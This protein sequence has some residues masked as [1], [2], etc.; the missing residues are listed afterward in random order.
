MATFRSSR[1]RYEKWLREQL[2]SDL[3]LADLTKKSRVMRESSFKFLRAT[4]WRWSE[5]IAE[6]CPEVVAAPLV[7]AVG[8]IHLENFGTW[9]DAEGRL[10]FGVNDF[11]EAAEM[12]FTLDLVRLAAS[13][14]LGSDGRKRT[15]ADVSAAI[16]AGYRQGLDAP[17]PI[18]LDREWH[19]LRNAVV[20][21]EERRSKFW[22]EL[23]AVVFEPAPPRF[24]RALQRV[25]PEGSSRLQTARRTAGTGSLGRPRWLG[26]TAWRGAPAIREAKALLT[27]GWCLAQGKPNAAL[28][29]DEIAGGRF[30]SPDPWYRVQDAIVVRRLSPNNRKF[31]AGKRSAFLHE[32]SLH[33]VMGH[34]LASLHLGTRSQ[35]NAIMADLKK[36]PENWL[37]IAAIASADAVLN[38]FKQWTA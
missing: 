27:S 32:A 20:V 24:R 17:R 26:V 2:G 35:R 23:D 15:A 36:R 11:D 34:E 28:L 29:A 10:V 18:I 12:P 37:Q 5:T 22:K 25:M 4:Y 38:D 1:S 3:A 16:L 31:E 6:V 13:A 21:P 33:E 14:L 9:R 19:W 30:R 7:I 8:D